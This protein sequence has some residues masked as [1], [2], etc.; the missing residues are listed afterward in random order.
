MFEIIKAI[1]PYIVGGIGTLWGFV[2]WWLK[3]RAE[4]RA[5]KE[6]AEMQQQHEREMAQL[7]VSLTQKR[8]QNE[9]QAK[10]EHAKA[11]H[12]RYQQ[13]AAYQQALDVCRALLCMMP[14]HEFMS[15]G[16]CSGVFPGDYY[17]LLMSELEERRTSYQAGLIP[18]LSASLQETLAAFLDE[19]RNFTSTRGMGNTGP[20][21]TVFANSD[22]EKRAVT[23]VARKIQEEAKASGISLKWSHS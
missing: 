16:M 9:A 17:G 11:E 20:I 12:N 7:K 14:P 18:E 15:P 21:V 6:L 23:A 22:D 3:H 4:H 10:A 2:F 19:A 8:K 13:Q 5:R 1:A